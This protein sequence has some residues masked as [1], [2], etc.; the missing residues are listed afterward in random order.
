MEFFRGGGKN[1]KF[2]TCRLP[3]QLYI[4]CFFRAIDRRAVVI[5]VVVLYISNVNKKYN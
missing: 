1:V 3:L 2:L 4:L 5:T